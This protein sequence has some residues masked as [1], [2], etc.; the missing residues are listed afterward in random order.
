MVSTNIPKYQIQKFETTYY[1]DLLPEFGIGTVGKAIMT[2]HTRKFS[3][4]DWWGVL[5]N[6]NAQFGQAEVEFVGNQVDSVHINFNQNSNFRNSYS[7]DSQ[8]RV[9]KFLLE[10]LD[11]A[12]YDSAQ[13]HS[14]EYNG[15]NEISH[16]LKYHSS[17]GI[18]KDSMVYN[19]NDD[20]IEYYVYDY[21]NPSQVI[22]NFFSYNNSFLEEV[23]YQRIDN[24]QVIFQTKDIWT[25]NGTRLTSSTRYDWDGTSLGD[26]LS[27]RTLN[28]TQNRLIEYIEMYDYQQSQGKSTLSNILMMNIWLLIS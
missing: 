15:T 9:S 3:T 16:Q 13:I 6:Q 8:N 1:L 14:Y 18:I 28:G 23:V 7:Y 27:T 24:G 19:T 22:V 12:Q 11:G 25:N 4:M 21:F 17:G 20:L 10:S 26:T 5:G 2:P